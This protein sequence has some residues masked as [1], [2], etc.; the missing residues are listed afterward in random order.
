M[1]NHKEKLI[2]NLMEKQLRKLSIDEKRKLAINLIL[3][4][5]YFNKIH[6]KIKYIYYEYILTDDDIEKKKIELEKIKL[7]KILKSSL[8]DYETSVDECEKYCDGDNV[9]YVI[10]NKRYIEAYLASKN[11]SKYIDDKLFELII[12]TYKNTR[13]TIE[14]YG[15]EVSDDEDQDQ[16]LKE[17]IKIL[18][19]NSYLDEAIK[20]NPKYKEY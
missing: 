5:E 9:Y 2:Y 7:I 8:N 6:D 18:L 14:S 15:G 19:K 10:N 13:D 1:K 4:D 11:V 3:S 16:T 12:E 20:N 17:A